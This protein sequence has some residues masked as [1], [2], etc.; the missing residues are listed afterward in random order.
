MLA[1]IKE[2]RTAAKGGEKGI[3]F[4]VSFGKYRFITKPKATG[5]KTTF[6]VL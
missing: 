6:T 4:W 5:R 1:T 3:S 2:I